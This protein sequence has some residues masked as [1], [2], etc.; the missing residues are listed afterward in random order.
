MGHKT[1][2]FL[3]DDILDVQEKEE[4]SPTIHLKPALPK[5]RT[6]TEGGG[7]RKLM[8]KQ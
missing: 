7:E 1:K 6:I 8:Q 2:F 4:M 3:N 5:L